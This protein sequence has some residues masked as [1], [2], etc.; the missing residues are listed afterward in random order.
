MAQ[1]SD[2]QEVE[3]LAYYGEAPPGMIFWRKATIVG[4]PTP[5]PYNPNSLLYTAQFDDGSQRQFDTG[6]IRLPS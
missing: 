4:D 1:F 3:V 2:G 5:D 6:H